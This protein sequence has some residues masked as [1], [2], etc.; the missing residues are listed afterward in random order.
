MAADHHLKLAAAFDHHNDLWI[1]LQT[2]SVRQLVVVELKAQSG[3]AVNQTVNI[4]FAADMP[5]YVLSEC[6][7]F[8]INT[9]IDSR[10]IKRKKKPEKT[11]YSHAAISL[12]GFA[13]WK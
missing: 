11:Y 13:C 3:G 6:L 7:I 12:S 1:G 8:H 2:F 9:R 10:L 4:L 5:E